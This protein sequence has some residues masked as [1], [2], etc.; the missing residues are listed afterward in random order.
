MTLE[1]KAR[2]ILAEVISASTKMQIGYSVGLP[3][4]PDLRLEPIVAALFSTRNEALDEAATVAYRGVLHTPVEIAMAIR[5][6]KETGGALDA[7][8]K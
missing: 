6:L 7:K 1:D 2:E 3:D 5:A 4:L 8:H